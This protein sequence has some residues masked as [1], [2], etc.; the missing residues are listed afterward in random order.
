MVTRLRQSRIA[1]RIEIDDGWWT[2]RDISVAIS[3]LARLDLQSLVEDHGAGKCLF[4]ANVRLHARWLNFVLAAIVVAAVSTIVEAPFA[5][6]AWV[7][8]VVLA[9]LVAGV[10]VQAAHGSVVMRDTIRRVAAQFHMQAIVPRPRDMARI[11]SSER[12][13]A[14]GMEV[15]RKGVNEPRRAASTMTPRSLAAGSRAVQEPR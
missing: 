2:G 4:R 9:G 13:V 5:D 11:L 14:R 8:A 6:L 7:P 12:R 10:I 1:H 3:P 15:R